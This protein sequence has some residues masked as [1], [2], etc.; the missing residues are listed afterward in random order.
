[1][2]RLT[3]ICIGFVAISLIFAGISDA[4]IDQESVAG[5]WLFN[6]SS[7][8]TATDSSENGNDGRFMGNPQRVD[9]KFDSKALEFDGDGDYVEVAH[10]PS[11]DEIND[12]ITIVVWVKGSPQ[13]NYPRIMCKRTGAVGLEIQ[14]HPNVATIAIRIDTT[15]FVN[16]LKTME[17]LDGQWHHVAYVLDE[18]NAKGYK[19]GIKATDSGYNHVD[20]FASQDNLLIGGTAPFTGILD[21]FAIFNTALDEDDIADIMNDGLA[22]VLGIGAAVSPSGKLTTTWAKLK[23]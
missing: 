20:G 8:D 9:G 21:E 7:G 22:E 17:I 3:V 15:G 6:E 19:D 4:K 5:V 16:Q 2:T 10:S 14:V 13:A 23:K 11:L 18:G 12:E 1:M